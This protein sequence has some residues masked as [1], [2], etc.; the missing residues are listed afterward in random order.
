MGQ[1]ISEHGRLEKSLAP[2]EKERKNLSECLLSESGHATMAV[3]EKVIQ[4]VRLNL[5]GAV[6]ELTTEDARKCWRLTED[7]L[8]GSPLST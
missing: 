7:G 5:Y 4:G 6:A 2:L 8:V 3:T 1:A